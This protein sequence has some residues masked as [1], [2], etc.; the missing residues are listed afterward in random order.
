MQVSSAVKS[1]LISRIHASASHAIGMG[2]VVTC[3]RENHDRPTDNST[4]KVF[5]CPTCEGPHPAYFRTCNKSNE[6]KRAIYQKVTENISGSEAQKRLACLAS[7]TFA[8]TAHG[9]GGGAERL[10]VSAGTQFC[11]TDFFLPPHPKGCFRQPSPPPHHLPSPQRLWW[12]P[13][14]S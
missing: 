5:K 7:T 6:E 14:L 4:T 10:L 1:Y 13:T 11:E 3:V 8:D 9:E 2:M 12:Q